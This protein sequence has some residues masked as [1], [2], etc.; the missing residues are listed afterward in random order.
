MGVKEYVQSEFDNVEAEIISANKDL[1]PGII[2]FDDFPR[3]TRSSHY[4]VQLLDSTKHQIAKVVSYR[5]ILSL[6]CTVKAI[7]SKGK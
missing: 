4:L 1:F 3:R 6:K 5:P 2:T 7:S